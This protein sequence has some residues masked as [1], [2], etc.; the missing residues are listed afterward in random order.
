MQE[1]TELGTA[2]PYPIRAVDRVCDILDTLAN[3]PEGVSLKTV[4]AAVSMPKSSV[5]R[6]LTA[7]EA[8]HYVERGAESA[9]F[10][11]GPAFRPQHTRSLEHLVDLAKPALEELRDDLGETMNLGYLDGIDVVHALVVESKESMRLAARVGD[12]EPVHSTALGK[13]ICATLPAAKVTSILKASGM[14]RVT[15]LTITEPAEFM[16]ALERVREQGYAIDDAEN[17]MNGRCVAVAI[18]GLS[19]PAALSVSAPADRFLPEQVAPVAERLR[20][21]AAALARQN[22]G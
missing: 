4:A 1:D 8:R 21:V 12:R 9:T 13:A 16:T 5:Y 14:P 17:Q 2:S 3:S 11:L 15:D 6:Y 19:F 10:Q 7:L 18:R 20:D 22:L